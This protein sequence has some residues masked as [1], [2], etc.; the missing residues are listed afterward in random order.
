VTLG[1]R[2]VNETPHPV[3]HHSLPPQCH[4]ESPN[5]APGQSGRASSVGAAWL[6]RYAVGTP[7]SWRRK[8]AFEFPIRSREAVGN[9]SGG[10]FLLTNSPFFYIVITVRSFA[11]GVILFCFLNEI[12]PLGGKVAVPFV[13]TTWKEDHYD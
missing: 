10:I 9:G 1:E 8:S 11:F 5:R 3:I 12:T 7:L 2:W 13:A 6:G 4:S